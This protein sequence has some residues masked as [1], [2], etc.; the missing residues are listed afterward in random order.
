MSLPSFDPTKAVTFDLARGL[1]RLD[2]DSARLLVPAAALLALVK[3]A[4]P[5]ASEA[6]GRA[7][8]EPLGER[9]ARRL[10]G[11]QALRASSPD[12]VLDHLSGE[13]AVIGLGTLSIERWGRALLLVVDRS[14]LA[15]DNDASLLT[16]VLE[17][18]LH[19][20]T[21][22]PVKCVLLSGGAQSRFLITGDAAARHAREWI[23]SGM[24]WGE[25]LARLHA[26]SA[27]GA[28]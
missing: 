20:A 1:V 18:A 4:G 23:A 16:Q 10:S 12:V 14:P 15:Q 19:Q 7:L 22:R 9:V 5:A 2:D 26:P 13:M 6:F 24:S 8:G 3:A 11:S 28:A 27:G 17:A 25:V 21:G